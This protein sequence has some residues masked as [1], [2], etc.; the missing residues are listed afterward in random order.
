[1]F[2]QVTKLQVFH[3]DLVLI[4]HLQLRLHQAHLLILAQIHFMV[5][6]WDVNVLFLTVSVH[7]NKLTRLVAV[8]TGLHLVAPHVLQEGSRR[9]VQVS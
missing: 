9:Q 1:M 6:F 7:T 2:S 8:L 5:Q 3:T 4:Q